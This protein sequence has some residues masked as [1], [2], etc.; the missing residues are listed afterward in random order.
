MKNSSKK[1]HLESPTHL[2]KRVKL[3]S[4]L[5]KLSSEELNEK[6]NTDNI[7][8]I[9]NQLS[10]STNITETPIN[11]HIM[12]KKKITGDIISQPQVI[13]SFTRYKRSH[14]IIYERS[15]QE[16]EDK[17][18]DEEFKSLF[19]GQLNTWHNSLRGC[20]VTGEDALD[21]ILY[22]L[23]LCYLS[24]KV[25][26]EGDFDL[27]NSEKSCY[28]GIIPRKI[29][30]WITK[31]NIDYLIENTAELVTYKEED[32]SI[33]KCGE[34]L[35]RHPITKQL[36]KNKS[37]INCKNKL[38]LSQLLKDCKDFSTTH[39]IFNKI[40]IIGIAWEYFNTK[41]GGNGGTSKERGQYFTER[42]V[43]GMCCQLIEPSHIEELGIDNDSTMG[44]EFCATFGFPLYA[45]KFLNQKFNI[46]IQDKKMYG[47]EFADRLSR[48]GIM[49]AMFSLT[50]FKNIRSGDSFITNVSPHLDV[51]VHN[52]PFGKSMKCDNIKE[53]YNSERAKEDSNL[54]EFKDVVPIEKNGDAM[55]SCQ[56]VVYKTKKMGLV[57]IK[58]GE[59]TTGSSN[60]KWR[61]WF[62]DS[63]VIHKIM[64]I[65]TGAFSHTGTKTVCIYF[66]KRE[67]Q[68]TE[69]I[70]FLEMSDTGDKIT[71]ICEVTRSDLQQNNYSWDPNVYIVDE[72]MEKLME[73]SGC[74]WKKLGEVCEKIKGPK[75]NSKNGEKIG[76][77]P[78]YYCSI[79]G[80]LYVKS[81]DYEDIGIIINKTNGSGKTNVYLGKNKYSVGETTIHFKS[82]KNNIKTEYIYYYLYYNKYI[83][84]NYY[85]GSNQ[86]SISD[87]DL[88]SINIPTPPQETQTQ[89]VQTLDDLANLRQNYMD[90]RDGLERRMKYYF[91]MMIKRHR[92]EITMEK[93]GDVCPIVIG[94]TPSTKENKFWETGT[95]TWVS[96]RELNNTTIPITNSV[97]KLTDTAISECN[98]RLVKKGSILMSFKLS[99]GKMAIAGCDLY[100]NEAIVHINT[101]NELSN[102]WLYYYYLCYPPIGASGSIGGGSLNKDK[103]KKIEF[104]NMPDTIKTQIV[105]Y[106][107]N[108]ETEKNKITETLHQLDTEM[109]EILTQ[110]YQSG[111]TIIQ[112]IDT[113][114][115]QVQTLQQMTADPLPISPGEWQGDV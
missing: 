2:K 101:N 40:D 94:S 25:S 37:F 14:I 115:E 45:K 44:D 48:F 106:L 27:A 86:K 60:K 20:S 51:S 13:K 59:E 114:V 110:S 83:L 64:K 66:T 71:E 1:K 11:T 35:S 104:I 76:K 42:P 7:T 99:I 102:K 19:M 78:V 75:V 73:S 95:H 6:Y 46:S 22:C 30:D 88:F 72:E 82:I 3:E 33:Y 9:L 23:F 70:Q 56:V 53:S 17:R 55:L 79:L 38:I 68:K 5:I 85:K 98:P 100:T 16:I 105:Q 97:K 93:L 28:K 41:H 57:I 63:C 18:Q 103:L 84:E 81:Y 108:L 77:Y 113:S 49:N 54:P 26:T 61:E 92:G 4:D 80:N 29:K 67:G 89:V 10:G 107:D 87:I 31:L 52:V 36:I 21:D 15:P 58:D 32:S 69:K 65:P 109:R 90:I 47:V 34:L 96:V 50:N 43:M 12:E 111:D 62:C 39:N 91:E 112:T 8:D 24:H 74:E